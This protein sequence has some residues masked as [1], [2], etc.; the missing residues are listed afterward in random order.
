[1]ASIFLGQVCYGA[2]NVLT[3]FVRAFLRFGIIVRSA[4]THSDT[5]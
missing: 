1:M 3:H 2:A 5:F 4:A